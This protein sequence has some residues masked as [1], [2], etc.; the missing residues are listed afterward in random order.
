MSKCCIAITTEPR[1]YRLSWLLTEVRIT[2]QEA[3]VMARA[4][5]SNIPLWLRQQE[6]YVGQRCASARVASPVGVG[7][8]S[9]RS[10]L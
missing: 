4:V 7:H 5:Y 6:T 8:R 9:A 1:S 10:K 2:T 3:G